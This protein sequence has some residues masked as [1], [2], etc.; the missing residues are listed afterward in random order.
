[1]NATHLRTPRSTT[2]RTVVAALLVG[3]GLAAC[4]PAGSASGPDDDQAVALADELN[5][6]LAVL[7]QPPV[8]TE[9]ATAL[10]GTDG[11]ISCENVAGLQQ[12][13]GLSQFGNSSLHLR[14]VVLDPSLVAYDLAV[15]ETYCP[16]KL[17]DLADVLR[18]LE[19]AETVPTS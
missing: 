6:N 12:E 17:G 7:D 15:V 16:E 8:D 2:L 10:Y 19:T 3:L 11:G 9:I 14:R 13:I 4:T 5:A 1:M 18:E